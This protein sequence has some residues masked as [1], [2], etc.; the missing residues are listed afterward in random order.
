MTGGFAASPAGI[1]PNVLSDEEVVDTARRLGSQ[2]VVSSYNEPL[3]TAEWAGSIFEQAK[4]AGLTTGFVSNGNATPEVLDYLRPLTHCYKVDLKSMRQENYRALGGQ[5]SLASGGRAKKLV[6][7]E[8]VRSP[9][10]L[11]ECSDGI[12]LR[13]NSVRA[14]HARRRAGQR[15]RAPDGPPCSSR[16]VW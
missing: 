5:L 11:R 7:G 13:S 14:S 4:E 15:P 1:N 16:P 10:A 6:D 2:L 8:R 12:A 9:I 3:I